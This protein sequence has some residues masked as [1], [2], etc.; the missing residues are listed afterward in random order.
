MTK[1]DIV[2]VDMA[3]LIV[4]NWKSNKTRSEVVE[5]VDSW[6]NKFP[7]VALQLTQKQISVAVAPPYPFLDVVQPLA[8]QQALHVAVQDLSPFESG[9]YTGAVS[10]RNLQEYQVRYAIV[11]HSERR[12]YF[13][14][15]HQDVA[16]KVDQALRADL[17]PIVC[18]DDEYL[19]AQ[20]AAI[21]AE[22]LSHCIVAYEPLESIGSG[23]P[24]PPEEVEPVVARVKQVFGP[25]PVLYGG[26]VT[27]STILDY[28]P[29]T[30][31][32]L[33]GG[34]SLEVDEFLA[35]VQR[36]TS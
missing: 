18:L 8:S 20:A 15:T 16:K 6:L 23:D 24:Q 27:S 11:G 36:A 4:A 31:G 21:S 30:D 17:T 25:V 7:P 9:S 26:S 13:H 5:W 28:L 22:Q 14:E 33:V 10:T 2:R 29:F 3:E 19:Q 12:Q 34:A 1:S 32:A 35:L